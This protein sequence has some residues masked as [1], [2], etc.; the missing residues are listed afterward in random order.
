M[1]LLKNNGN[2]EEGLGFFK[3]LGLIFIALKLMGYI[4]WSWIWVLA[5]LWGSYAVGFLIII[6]TSIVSW[7]KF[8]KFK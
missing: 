7:W 3:I 2:E 8:K 5:P 6:M 1:E 4:K